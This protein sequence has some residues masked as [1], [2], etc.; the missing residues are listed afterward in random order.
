MTCKTSAVEKRPDPPQDPNQS[1]DPTAAAFGDGLPD[2]LEPDD[3]Q[4][5]PVDKVIEEIQGPDIQDP[6]H[7]Y[8]PE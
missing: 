6:N 4:T 1:P 8:L 2:V 5:L 7:T 3:E